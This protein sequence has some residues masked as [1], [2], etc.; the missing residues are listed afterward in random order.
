M[1]HL[2]RQVTQG[3]FWASNGDQLAYVP[4]KHQ[5][6]NIDSF[7]SMSRERLDLPIVSGPA[8]S[9]IRLKHRVP[10]N[11]VAKQHA[12]RTFTFLGSALS[13]VRDVAVSFQSNTWR[14]VV[15][16]RKKRHIKNKSMSHQISWNK[17]PRLTSFQTAA[18][19]ATW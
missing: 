9:D 15:W 6:Q 16:V 7:L 11:P 18:G 13:H 5:I 12:G 10:P 1:C 17:D 4:L 19:L 14:F 3:H 8:L 2:M